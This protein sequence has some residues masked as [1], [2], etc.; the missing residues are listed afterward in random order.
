MKNH[1]KWIPKKPIDEGTENVIGGIVVVLA[2]LAAIFISG[3]A[4]PAR[5]GDLPL[6]C[7]DDNGVLYEIK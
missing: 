7:R 4:S 3:C 6:E 2:M 5:W 1:Y